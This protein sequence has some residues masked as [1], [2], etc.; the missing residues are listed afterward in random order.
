MDNACWGNDSTPSISAVGEALVSLEH[1]IARLEEE[2]GRLIARR[3]LVHRKLFICHETIRQLL[4][5]AG[6]LYQAK[7]W[8]RYEELNIIEED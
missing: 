5:K 3:Q 1:E 2:E 7:T 8:P 6:G 4:L